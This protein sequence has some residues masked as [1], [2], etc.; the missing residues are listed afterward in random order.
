MQHDLYVHPHPRARAAYPLIAVLHADVAEGDER[1]V[2]PL[3]RGAEV[4]PSRMRPR[5][6]HEGDDYQVLVRLLGLVP[7][8]LLRHPVGSVAAWRDDLTRAL[9]WLFFGI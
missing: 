7:T 6:Q 1:V 5:I 4:R 9:D 8:R 2:A 3:I